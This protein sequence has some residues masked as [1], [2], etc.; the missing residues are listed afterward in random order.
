LMLAP[1]VIFS[2]YQQN[3]IKTFQNEANS[4]MITKI[5]MVFLGHIR[6]MYIFKL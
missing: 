6:P 3:L 2:S 5:L 4:L 1:L